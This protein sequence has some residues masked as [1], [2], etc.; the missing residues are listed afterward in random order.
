MIKFIHFQPVF[1]K[2][3]MCSFKDGG[4]VITVSSIYTSGVGTWV[5]QSEEKKIKD[6]GN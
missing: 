5:A 6:G 2:P 1:K 3:L 4:R